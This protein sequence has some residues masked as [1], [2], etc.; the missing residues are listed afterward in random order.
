MQEFSFIIA[1]ILRKEN[2]VNIALFIL[3][4][5]FKTQSHNGDGRDTCVNLRLRG[6]KRLKT[7]AILHKDKHKNVSHPTPRKRLTPSALVH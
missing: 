1:A 7:E 6:M 5:E 3:I 2:C 4:W